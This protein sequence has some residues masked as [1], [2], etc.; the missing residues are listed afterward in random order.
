MTTRRLTTFLIV[1]LLALVAGCGGGDDSGGS[2]GDLG[3]EL[4]YLP[5]NSPLV[6]TIDTD[7]N[8]QQYKNLD[9]LLSKFPFGGQLKNQIKQ[10]IDQ[11]GANYDKD[12]KPLLGGE[13]VVGATDAKSLVDDSAEDQFVVVFTADGDKFEEIAKKDSSFKKTDDIDGNPVYQSGSDDVIMIKGD[14]LI[15]AQTREQV[16][17]AV[18]RHDGDDKLTEGDFNGAF[19]GLPAKPLV[20]VYGDAQ[21]LLQADPSTAD[22]QKVKWVAGLRKFGVTVAAEGDGLALDAH[23]STEGVAPQDLPIAAGNQAPG[24]ARFGDYSVAQRD[25]A[26]SWNFLVSVGAATDTEG[27]GDFEAKKKAAGKELGID[28]DK[29][30][31]D[32][33]KGD[34]TVAGTFDGSWSLRSDVADPAAMKKTVDKMAKSGGTGDVKFTDAGDLV[35]AQG[36]GD[37]VFFGMVDDT[38]VAGPTPDAAKQIATVEPQAVKGSKGSMV[39]VADGEAL[40]K[41]IL[42]RSGQGGGAA[43]LFT[44]PVGDITAFVTAGPDG[45]NARAKLK[46]E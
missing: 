18:D 26:Q 39:F 23:V 37:R 36:N 9:K 10:S 19:G 4:G 17:A 13:L 8:G 14:T 16:Q 31:V 15:A 35:L 6:I 28:L 5:K 44:G 32:Q 1:A 29:D 20:R 22:A 2:K 27:F 7:I 46:I 3:D 21:A 12:V 43:G 33:F 30:F 25:L 45:M 42:Q 24:L 34:T 38:F 41:S 40:A 11:Q